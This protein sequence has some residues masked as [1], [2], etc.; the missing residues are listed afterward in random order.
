MPCSH[1]RQ[2][3]HTFA[4]CPQLTPE[5]IK[6]KKDAIKKAK[7][8]KEKRK[9]QRLRMK[10]LNTT[11]NYVFVN[12]NMYE[13]VVY[14]SYTN[15]PENHGRRT[16]E[17][18]RHMYISPMEEKTI[19]LCQLYRIVILPVLEVLSPN[20]DN[21]AMQ[22]I[23]INER[24]NGYFK[25]LDVELDKYPSENIF[26]FSREY[27]PPK[28]D[29]DQWK[30]FALKSNYLL[31]EIQKMTT[32]NKKDEDGH[33]IYHEKYENIDTFLQMIQEIP[34]PQNCTEA[35]KEKAGIPSTLTNIT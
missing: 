8:D 5:Q 35:D 7:E 30:E 34:L 10:Q 23:P 18:I 22:T 9:Q 29:L 2:V 24:Y 16:D 6:E 33:I 31:K 14:F 13:V 1:C 26:E 11:K 12:K 17:L 21:N 15:I 32:T 20:H 28:S 25:L 27:K 4:K 19:I 3:G